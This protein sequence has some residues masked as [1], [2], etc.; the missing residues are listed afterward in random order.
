[1]GQVKGG[2]TL[3]PLGSHPSSRP[4]SL[5]I[6]SFSFGAQ[7]VPG[8]SWEPSECLGVPGRESQGLLGSPG[9]LWEFKGEGHLKG[10]FI[11]RIV[12]GSSIGI[13]TCIRPRFVLVCV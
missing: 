2:G 9:T 10:P 8:S 3:G 13:L 5:E 4:V 12:M 6:P 7:R 1:M 11:N